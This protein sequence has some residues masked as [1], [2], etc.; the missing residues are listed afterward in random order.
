MNSHRPESSDPSAS[1]QSSPTTSKSTHSKSAHASSQAQTSELAHHHT[2]TY[3][4][5]EHV[6]GQTHRNGTQRSNQ[7]KKTA[8]HHCLNCSTTYERHIASKSS[9]FFLFV[10]FLNFFNPEISNNL[11]FLPKISSNIFAALLFPIKRNW[12]TDVTLI[13]FR[14][15]LAVSKST[16]KGLSILSTSKCLGALLSSPWSKPASSNVQ[17]CSR[18][19]TKTLR[20]SPFSLGVCSQSWNKSPSISWDKRNCC[21]P[22]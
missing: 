13:T 12:Q 18:M 14:I 3:V 7:A 19:S 21:L 9:K 22:Q 4:W 6:H 16:M 11:F 17:H 8:R 5:R 15:V 2:L 20:I 1:K 10:F